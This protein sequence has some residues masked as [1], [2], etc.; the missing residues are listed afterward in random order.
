MLKS[1]VYYVVGAEF[2]LGII[3]LY[4]LSSYRVY[5]ILAIKVNWYLFMHSAYVVFNGKS[6]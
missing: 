2:K 1:I 6:E 5:E 4:A 3:E